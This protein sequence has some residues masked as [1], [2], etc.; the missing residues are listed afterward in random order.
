M[1]FT[2]F[3]AFIG[4]TYIKQNFPGAVNIPDENI[5][6]AVKVAQEKHIVNVL[7]S[8]LYNDITSAIFDYKNSGTPVSAQYTYL[9]DNYIAPCLLHYSILELIPTHYSKLTTIGIVQK[10]SEYSGPSERTIVA[11]LMKSIENTADF[12][13][14]RLHN[15]LCDNTTLYPKYLQASATENINPQ[16]NNIIGGLFLYN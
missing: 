1:A 8:E 5:N 16:D 9:R 7:G 14:H 13:Y 15:H 3:A 2:N 4:S 6:Y 12:Y 11:Q 10:T